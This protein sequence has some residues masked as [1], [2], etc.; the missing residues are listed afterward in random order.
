MMKIISVLL[1]LSAV[2]FAG[3]LEAMEDACER[4]VAE[5][6]YELGS[7]YQ[8]NDGIPKDEIK[9]DKYLAKA[10]DLGHEKSCKKLKK[11]NIQQL[12]DIDE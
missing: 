10:C 5:A 12:G 4:N 3:V 11:I 7:I 1:L 2:S 9:A 6:C 8:G